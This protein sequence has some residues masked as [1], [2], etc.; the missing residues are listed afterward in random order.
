M[1][2]FT[3]VL[4]AHPVNHKLGGPRRAQIWAS[5]KSHQNPLQVKCLLTLPFKYMGGEGMSR[6]AI[7]KSL[8][9]RQNLLE[10]SSHSAPSYGSSWRRGQ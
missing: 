3:I 10:I 7:D 1:L 8:C 4:F 9:T 2:C 5:L 6:S